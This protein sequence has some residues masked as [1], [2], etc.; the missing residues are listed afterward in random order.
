MALNPNNVQHGTAGG[1]AI[2][3][4][5]SRVDHAAAPR[6]VTLSANYVTLSGPGIPWR[7]GATG[8]SAANLEYP[9]TITNGTRVLLHA[10]EAAVLV[11]AG[12]AAFS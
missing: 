9:K 11:A 3:V 2:N 1:T 8:A 4:D 5:L 7:P 10:A 12:K 6:F